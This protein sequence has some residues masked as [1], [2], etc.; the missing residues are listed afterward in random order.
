M[1]LRHAQQRLRELRDGLRGFVSSSRVDVR[2]GVRAGLG[3]PFVGCGMGFGFL[4]SVEVPFIGNMLSA[5]G[6]N[7]TLADANLGG[8]GAGALRRIGHATSRLVPGVRFGTGCGVAVGYGYGAGLFLT[9]GEWI[10]GGL[11]QEG[12]D[13]GRGT[14]A[15][16]TGGTGETAVSARLDRLERRVELL[17]SE[18]RPAGS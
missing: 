8:H 9:P 12:E 7:V 4:S 18:R 15:G 10:G 16:A 5:V 2:A 17:E 14:G 11:R 3:V 6:Q 13:T 1:D